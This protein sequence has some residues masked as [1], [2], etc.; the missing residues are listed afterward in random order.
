VARRRT[1]FSCGQA[2]SGSGAF[3]SSCGKPVDAPDLEMLAGDTSASEGTDV[4]L[5]RSGSRV[6]SVLAIGVVVAA[7]GGAAAFTG[8]SAKSTSASTTTT[9]PPSTS[10]T[11]VTTTTVA[12]L[13]PRKLDALP[14]PGE[15][16]GAT[17]LLRGGSLGD[18]SL[19]HS[20]ILDVDRGVLTTLDDTR[21][22]DGNQIIF[23]P[24]SKGLVATQVYGD[25]SI[26][27]WQRDGSVR[28]VAAA[29]S[30]SGTFFGGQVVFAGDTMW[31]TEYNP[32]GSGG[33]S[34]TSFSFR[35][36]ERVVWLKDAN[37]IS[38]VG[39][40]KRGRPVMN[41]ADGGAYTFDPLT[42]TFARLTG[43]P[44]EVASEAG[45]VE[46]EC[47]ESLTCTD[48]FR[49]ADGVSHPLNFPK[50]GRGNVSLSP[51]GTHAV[52]Q[53]YEFGSDRLAFDVAD[54]STGEVVHLG[55][56]EQGQRPFSLP[57][58][59]GDGRWLFVQLT[60]GLAA[61]REGLSAPVIMQIDGKPIE[62][63][64]VGVF[65]N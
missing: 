14:L 42:R 36:G 10:T 13:V 17:L 26:D 18:G 44:V 33:Q 5:A 58:W 6:R 12:P 16:T 15:T 31:A 20:R 29:S 41:G 23:A 7:I 39:V 61:W 22:S 28:S 46:I 48:V 24:T 51:D 62:S 19:G 56:F 9:T 30:T 65:P 38:L 21:S 11:E 3:C 25:G 1:C 49:G 8:S 52:K 50:G 35:D 54:T 34:L 59:T 57:V 47:T 45:R 27:L 60:D 32:G 2:Q 55:E 53:T 40:D 43:A 37:D 4:T 63:F 64:A